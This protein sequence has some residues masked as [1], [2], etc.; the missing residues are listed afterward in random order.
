[1]L[2]NYSILMSVYKKEKPDF[3][4]KA[5]RSMLDQTVLTD[6]FVIV[7]DGPLTEELDGI[8]EKYV[9]ENPG[10]FQIV[11]LPEN[12]GIGAAAQI[13]LTHCKN[14]LVAKM[15]GDDIAAPERCKLQ[16]ECFK[17]NPEISVL[18]GYIAE[19]NNS[20]DEL[21]NQRV[22][23]LTHEKICKYAKRRQPFNNQTVMFRKSAVEAVGGY[24]PLRRGEDYDLYT[25]LLNAGYKGKNLPQILTYM[26]VGGGVHGRRA[27]WVTYRTFV[28]T[29][30][31]A[32]RIGFASLWDFLVC[33]GVQ[34]VYFVSPSKLQQAFYRR[35]LRKPAN[36][37][38]SN[39]EER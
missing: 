32:Y 20:I 10:I 35:C 8:I 34:T 22:V 38:Q 1:M 28:V 26:R 33:V 39:A 11:R 18:G 19:F 21:L 4:K 3:F 13:G 16:L 27:S 36:V 12:K 17:N 29:R 30:W 7:C 9:N 25:R 23:P 5:I 15:D 2:E 6:D 14:E 31:N 24:K 37:T